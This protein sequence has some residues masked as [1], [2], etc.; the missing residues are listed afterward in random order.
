MRTLALVGLLAPFLLSCGNDVVN[1]SAPVG[2]TM[3]IKSTDAS[4]TTPYAI[5]PQ[6]KN[7]ATEQGNPYGAFVNDATRALGRAPSRIA[8]TSM[9]LSLLGSSKVVTTLNQVASQVAV[10]FQLVGT[11]VTPVGAAANPQGTT[12][13]MASSFDSANLDATA[14]ASLLGGSF[15][16]VLT[17]NAVSSF[18]TANATADLQVTFGFLAYK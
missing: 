6:S 18:P 4:A 2:I 17:G 10:G 16:V 5:N 14:Y 3:S 7:I 15:P 8:V 1:Y 9:T 12:F 13:P 11:T